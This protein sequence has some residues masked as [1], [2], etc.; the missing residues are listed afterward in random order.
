M[1]HSLDFG[2]LVEPVGDR[3]RRAFDRIETH[4]KRLQSAQRETAVVG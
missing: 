4:G 2:T 1:E 3:Q